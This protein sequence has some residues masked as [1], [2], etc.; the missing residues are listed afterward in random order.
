MYY[1]KL[2]ICSFELRFNFIFGFV[3]FSMI[4]VVLIS[5]FYVLVLCF[6]YRVFR[7]VEFHGELDELL[8]LSLY[9]VLHCGVHTQ[10]I[11]YCNP[12][13]PILI[14]TLMGIR[15]LK[16]SPDDQVNAFV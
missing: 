16:L 7:A 11:P 12:L 14:D 3:C 15:M 9:R 4:S 13:E 10:A 1:E 2:I 8:C 5:N 6:C